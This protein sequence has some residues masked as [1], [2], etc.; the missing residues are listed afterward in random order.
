MLQTSNEPLV[1]S[2][3]VEHRAIRCGVPG[4]PT[5]SKHARSVTCPDC[6]RMLAAVRDAT[7][8]S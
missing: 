6:L 1:H 4:H 2:Y 7:P 3:D 5:S 8:Q